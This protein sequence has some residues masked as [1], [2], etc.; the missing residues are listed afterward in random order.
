MATQKVQPTDFVNKPNPQDSP[1]L[2]TK[3]LRHFIYILLIIGI[4][5]LLLAWPP[6]ANAQVKPTLDAIDFSI[7]PGNRV[8]LELRLSDPVAEPQSFAI[9][10]PARIAIDF[11]GVRLNLEQTSRIIDIGLT[12]SV[13]AIEGRDRTRVVIQ[14]I[15]LVPYKMDIT[16]GTIFITIGES[17][18]TS[19]YRG[20]IGMGR[21][22][23][24]VFEP[25]NAG[26]GRIHIKLSD[27]LTVIDTYE[28][29]ENIIVE[30]FNT[31]LPKNLSRVLDVTDFATP[32][33]T[34]DTFA[35]GNN[36]RMVINTTGN[37]EHLAYQTRHQQ[38]I[39]LKKIK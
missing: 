19:S 31:D 36:T 26:V 16:N 18:D 34:I 21:I 7:L 24:I 8:R 9:H 27:P 2:R 5:I 30:F 38:S 11:P 20:E 23:D 37:Y 17:D 32:I 3:R 29:G 13:S 28:E 12:H 1:E 39:A 14:L 35:Q 6:A 33:L 25:G 22:E 10:H 15:R 4:T